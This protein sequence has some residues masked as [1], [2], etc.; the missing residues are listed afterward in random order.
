[1]AP[2]LLFGFR[3]MS[4]TGFGKNKEKEGWEE[5]ERKFPSLPTI[6]CLLLLGLLLMLL[7]QNWAI[8]LDPG[9]L[10]RHVRILRRC[11]ATGLCSAHARAT[12]LLLPL[13]LAHHLLLAN[14]L[15]LVVLHRGRGRAVCVHGA[16]LHVLK[17]HVVAHLRRLRAA[18]RATRGRIHRLHPLLSQIPR[19]VI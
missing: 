11:A 4:F 1:M 17:I 6:L 12:R 3:K 9:T 19:E 14:E 10:L 5:E 2:P 8:V 13:L 7:L 16:V 15:R 18:R